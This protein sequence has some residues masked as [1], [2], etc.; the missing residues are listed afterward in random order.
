M[1]TLRQAKTQ[2][3]E[4]IR[5]IF[6][7]AILNTTAVYTYNPFSTNDMDVWFQTKKEG[8]YPVVIA[9]NMADN[10]IGFATYGAFRPH[11]AFQFTAEHSVYVHP[12]HQNK[13]VASSLL[14]KLIELAKAN[15]IHSLVAGIDANNT[16]SISLHQKFGFEKAGI[17]KQSGFKFN[18]WLDLQFMQK[19][20]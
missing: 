12:N 1:V 14:T 11:A 10:V 9:V 17:I 2:D 8:N 15:N 7:H 20:L 5:S 13:G 3:L 18:Q 4:A 19:I 16:S 6:N